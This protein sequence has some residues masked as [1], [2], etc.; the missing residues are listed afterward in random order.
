MREF[1]TLG[2]EPYSA[3]LKIVGKW[4]PMKLNYRFDTNVYMIYTPKYIMEHRIA[5]SCHFCILNKAKLFA[6]LED[7]LEAWHLRKNPRTMMRACNAGR[8]MENWVLG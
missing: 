7:A 8:I 5:H 6:E 1:I 3:G 4:V 2:G